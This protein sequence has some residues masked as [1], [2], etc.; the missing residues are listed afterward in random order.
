MRKSVIKRRKRVP[1]GANASAETKAA[2]AVATPPTPA[3]R[4]S[5]SNAARAARELAQESS[6]AA[7]EAAMALMEVGRPPTHHAMP[8]DAA[9]GAPLE[10]ERRGSMDSRASASAGRPAKRAR[11]SAAQSREASVRADESPA[12]SSNLLAP[13]RGDA[14]GASAHDMRAQMHGTPSPQPPAQ[15]MRSHETPPG[16]NGPSSQ[17]RTS[18]SSASPSLPDEQQHALNVQAQQLASNGHGPSNGV[19]AHHHHREQH[20]FASPLT[21]ADRLLRRPP[22]SPRDASAR[23]PHTRAR[24]RAAAPSWCAH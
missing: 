1:Q 2:A 6:N 13:M 17:M 10:P 12:S 23:P 21:R 5:D 3:G 9:R 20:R 14:N 11:K 22:P 24:W 18:D 4:K 15:I 7:H 16:W 19:Q 8:Q